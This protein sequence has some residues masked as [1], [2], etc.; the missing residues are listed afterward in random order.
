M[1]FDDL[2]HFAVLAEELNFRRAAQRLDVRQPTLTRRIRR[3]EQELGVYLLERHAR[4]INL[5]RAGEIFAERSQHLIDEQAKLTSEIAQAAT[6]SFGE[7]SIGFY[8]SLASEILM[9]VL[10]EFS[11][12]PDVRINLFEKT[13]RHQVRDL[14]DG[15]I[16]LALVVGGMPDEDLNA[17][18]LWIERLVLALPPEYRLCAASVIG[19]SDLVNENLISRSLDYDRSASLF[20]EDRAAQFGGFRPHMRKFAVTRENIVTLV[21][22]GFGIAVLPESSARGLNM[23]DVHCRPIGGPGSTIEITGAWLPGNANP[24]LRRFLERITQVAAAHG[25]SP[26]TPDPPA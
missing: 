9:P 10:R 7:L 19:W 22:A 11:R 5:T 18:G 21:R 26:E 12:T 4:R 24:V 1:D 20:I 25:L 14:R 6:G 23:T 17:E 3:L 16:D 15:S 13:P 2:T 8:T